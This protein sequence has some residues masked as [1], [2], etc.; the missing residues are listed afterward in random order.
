MPAFQPS[1]TLRL[2]TLL[3]LSVI[4]GRAQPLNAQFLASTNPGRSDT[5]VVFRDEQGNQAEL[6]ISVI[7]GTR[8]GPTFTIVAGVHGFEYPPIVAVQQLLREV[9]SSKLSGRLIVIP[10]ANTASFQCRTPFMNPLDGKNLNNVFPGREI[11]SITERIAHFITTQIIP[12]SDVFL[13]VHGGDAGEDLMPFVCYYDHKGKASQTAAAARLCE[14]SGFE[15]VVSYPYTIHDTDAAKYAFKQAAQDGKIALSIESGRM[16]QVRP[17]DVLWI[18]TGV[19]RMLRTQGMY[20][21]G[22]REKWK[23][24]HFNGQSYAYAKTSGI[25]S[26]LL[27]AGSEVVKGEPIG[28]ITDAFGN[29]LEEVVAPASGVILYKIGTPPVNA[30]ET[31]CCVG[32][33]A[34]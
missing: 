31:V 3:L 1:C 5:L 20:R 19:F 32:F 17:V 13:D 15:N 9:D 33:V 25:F 12:H 26:S 28:V 6:P 2:F 14:K 7:R 30:G 27:R 24:R 4:T 18:K 11:G 21:Q 23:P 29:R 16:G 34:E 10:I 8:P 22:R